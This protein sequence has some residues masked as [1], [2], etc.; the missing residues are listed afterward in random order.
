MHALMNSR[1]DLGFGVLLAGQPRDLSR[2]R[3][4]VFPVS[5]VRLRARP[6]V[7]AAQ[8][9]R[10]LRRPRHRSRRHLVG[11]TQLLAGIQ[12]PAL[13]AQPFATEEMGASELHANTG[14]T[15]TTDRLEIEALGGIAVAQAR[16]QARLDP[17]RP[18]GAA[19]VCHRREPMERIRRALG[20][21]AAESGHD[22][23]TEAPVG[24]DQRRGL[25]RLAG[26]RVRGAERVEGERKLREGAGL[27]GELQVSSRQPPTSGRPTDLLR[28]SS[29]ALARLRRSRRDER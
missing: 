23:L 14:A 16:P 21:S 6:A 8:V 28:P 7:P 22:Q 4:Q 12:P 3:G 13:A 29:G 15:E 19:G 24:V 1:A 9:R 10:D 26:E 2:L 18:V 27:A 17:Q 20:L 5:T 25:G 11:S